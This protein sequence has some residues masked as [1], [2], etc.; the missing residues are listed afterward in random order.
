MSVDLSSVILFSFLHLVWIGLKSKCWTQSDPGVYKDT[1]DLL[2]WNVNLTFS[3]SSLYW[4]PILA[5]LFPLAVWF[6]WWEI[7][8]WKPEDSPL[9]IVT[10]DAP[11][12]LK[13]TSVMKVT[14]AILPECECDSL[15]QGQCNVMV[16]NHV[17][18]CFW[19]CRFYIRLHYDQKG[20]AY[21]I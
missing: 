5:A 19:L 16:K 20:H 8:L 4:A 18:Q 21:F 6:V 2:T 14:S 15:T 13:L 12:L 10:R 17:W 11:G 7:E 9:E 1:P 3:L